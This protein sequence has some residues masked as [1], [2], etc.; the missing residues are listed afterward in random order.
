[1]VLNNLSANK[2]NKKDVFK[3]KHPFCVKRLID[4]NEL[5]KGDIIKVNVMV[6]IATNKQ[7]KLIRKNSNKQ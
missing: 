7:Q 4:R 1:M 5:T 3:L 2:C 6:Q